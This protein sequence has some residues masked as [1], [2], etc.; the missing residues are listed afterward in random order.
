MKLAHHMTSVAARITTISLLLGT[1]QV[2]G[3]NHVIVRPVETDELLNN[4]GK[5]FTTF[6]MFN[7]DN[8]QPNQDVLKD[9][10]LAR[11]DHPSRELASGNCS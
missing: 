10:D 11:F 5:G 8:H 3:Q 2:S 9:L 1:M 6:Q 7:G 4:P